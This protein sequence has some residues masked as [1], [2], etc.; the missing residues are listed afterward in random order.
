MVSLAS[1]G[2]NLGLE[3]T[4]FNGKTTGFNGQPRFARQTADP[5]GHPQIYTHL[6]RNPPVVGAPIAIHLAAPAGHPDAV[7]SAA[8]PAVD[9]AAPDAAAAGRSN[10]RPTLYH[11]QCEYSY[12]DINDSD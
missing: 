11:H 10:L 2:N 7:V 1:L 12:L 8:A 6:F 9:P 5:Q 4:G 3:L